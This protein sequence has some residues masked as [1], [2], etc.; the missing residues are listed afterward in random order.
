VKSAPLKL[1]GTHFRARERVRV[2][3]FVGGSAILRTVTTTPTGSFAVSFPA[4]IWDS[5]LGPTHV[6]ATGNKGSRAVLKA[7]P[8]LSACIDL[9]P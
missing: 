2:S 5:C 8:R 4:A 3:G 6:A 1:A 9:A 7:A